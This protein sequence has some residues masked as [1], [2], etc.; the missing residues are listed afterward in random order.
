M[1]KHFVV[2]LPAFNII[3]D[4]SF[5]YFPT[6]SIV[7]YIRPV[8]YLILFLYFAKEISFNKLTKP[9]FYF[10]SYTFLLVLFSSEM[11]Y[12]FKGYMQVFIS[13]MTFVI[14]LVYFN[15]VH[16][17]NLLNKS[18]LF[19]LIFSV[20]A[21]AVGY[22][23]GIGRI[24]EYS[25][26]EA[27]TIGL[28]GSFGLYTAA[29]A[30]ALLPLVLTSFRKPLWRWIL[31]GSALIVYIF[32][33]LNVRRT[34]ILIPVV[35][36][37]TFAWFNPRRTKIVSGIIMALGFLILL[38]PYYEDKLVER[39]NLRKEQGRFDED[40]YKTEGR[41]LENIDLIAEVISFKD[42]L[43]SLF[44]SKIYASGWQDGQTTRQMHS[45]PA[46]LLDGTGILGLILYFL[47]YLGLFKTPGLFK[48]SNSSR[49]LLYKS[50]YFS[51]LFMSL[52][53]SLNGSLMIVSL[54]SMLFLYMGALLS[55]MYRY[56]DDLTNQQIIISR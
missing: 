43:K 30:I 8:V 10:L 2:L 34:A 55:L 5:S 26:K 52:F 27:D 42:P 54:R 46:G 28:L 29:A 32:I 53:A 39:Y 48:Q 47:I 35:G 1:N 44:G 23:F 33:L 25:G 9:L 56:S 14:G 6:L 3:M 22:L 40:F 19:V 24:L 17:L 16:K 11:F 4:S 20:A 49:Y 36:L 45:D 13:M 7:T 31:Y 37:L 18:I 38:S 50:T 15:S 41:Y 51:L 21:T 12:S